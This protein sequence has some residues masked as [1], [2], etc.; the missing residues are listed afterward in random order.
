MKFDII[1]IGGGVSSYWFLFLL[2]KVACKELNVI[3]IKADDYIASVDSDIVPILTLNG[4]EKGNSELG[5]LLFDSFIHIQRYIKSMEGFFSCSQYCLLS[6]LDKDNQK[7]LRRHGGID[8]LDEFFE[9]NQG[10]KLNSFI[11]SPQS[12]FKF[13]E[14][15]I[16]KSKFLKV[17]LMNDLVTETKD[18]ANSFQVKTLGGNRYIGDSLFEF[19]GIGSKLLPMSFL[20]M[21]KTYRNKISK[22]VIYK[23]Y[24]GLGQKPFIVT[25]DKCNFIYNGAGE[26]QLGG[27]NPNDKGHEFLN[28]INE[29]LNLDLRKI[30]LMRLEGMRDKGKKRLPLEHKSFKK[31]GVYYKL[32]GL[33]KNAWTVAPLKIDKFLREN[34]RFF[35]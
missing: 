12:W 14:E 9:G 24:S 19:C 26:F 32:H 28:I 5:D 31:S 2:N 25:Q 10:K 6:H 18:K 3:W 34:P 30:D 20:E 16:E 1:L 35:K 15:Q 4:I 11:V 17:S 22:G 33:Y 29:K 21:T 8:C 23:G 7:F 13:I 27:I